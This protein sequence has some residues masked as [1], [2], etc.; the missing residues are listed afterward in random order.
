L[1]YFADETYDEGIIVNDRGDIWNEIN[2]PYSCTSFSVTSQYVVIC[3]AKKKKK[4]RYMQLPNVD[5]T[6][7]IPMKN[8]AEM[9][10]TNDEGTLVWRI[11]KGVAYSPLSNEASC[12]RPCS[13]AWV[14]AANEGGGIVECALTRETAWYTTKNGEVYVQLRLPEMG[15]LSRC[16]SAWSLECI[17][18]SEV[19]VWALQSNTGRL[20]VR[21]GL[22]HC[23]LGLD[24]VE[25]ES[26]SV[27]YQSVHF[28]V[29]MLT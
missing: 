1:E 19:A 23:P 18:A 5:K 28:T 26:V 6:Q 20:V 2:L 10:Q 27:C 14:M 15:I 4:P 13:L 29:I 16:E 25:I 12:S 9:I 3:H 11:H 21:A 8:D 22:K 17:T 7:W 24:W